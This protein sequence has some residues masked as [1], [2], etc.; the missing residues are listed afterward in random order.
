MNEKSK[1]GEVTLPSFRKIDSTSN[2]N[3]TESKQTLRDDL[4]LFGSVYL[5]SNSKGPR[6]H[7]QSIF[8]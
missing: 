3:T 6:E 2:R 7:E 5:G 4:P 8:N 1:R